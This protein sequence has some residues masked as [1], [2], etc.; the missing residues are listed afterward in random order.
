MIMELSRNV[1]I[2][3]LNFN[4]VDSDYVRFYILFKYSIV[5]NNKYK[6]VCFTI[7]ITTI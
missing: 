2:S 4:P 1:I 6:I 5:K 7:R 3:L